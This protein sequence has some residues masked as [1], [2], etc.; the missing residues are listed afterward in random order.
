MY[1]CVCYLPPH[2]STYYAH[3]PIHPLDAISSD[4]HLLS[5]QSADFL[6]AGDFNARTACAP[7]GATAFDFIQLSPHIPELPPNLQHTPPPNIQPRINSDPEHPTPQGKHFLSVLSEHSLAIING[8]TPSDTPAALTCR[9]LN[10]N[11]GSTVDYF[12][13]SL[14]LFS[15][16]IDMEVLPRCPHSD[17]C[18]LILTIC[19][20][21]L[22]TSAPPPAA[23]TIPRFR[24]TEKNRDKNKEKNEQYRTALACDP[25]LSPPHL[26]SL[27][28]H[29]A[30]LLLQERIMH[31]ISTIY[32][33]LSPHPPPRH[34]NHHHHQP[35]FDEDCKSARRRYHAALIDPNSHLSH[36]RRL[37]YKSLCASKKTSHL[38]ARTARLL[39]DARHRP[40]AFWRHYRPPK[41][42]QKITSTATWHEY[43]SKLFACPPS[44]PAAPP[45]PP[46]PLTQQQA[47]ATAA[48]TLNTPI[49]ST[50]VHQ[51]LKRLRRNK[52]AGIDGMRAEFILDAATELTAPLTTTFN[53]L[54]HGSFPSPLNCQVVHS[55]FKGKG[56]PLD[57]N[58]Y[59]CLSVGPTLTKLYTMVLEARLSQWAENNGVRAPT[60]AGFR[61][62][63]RTTD[64][65]Y[66]LHTLIHQARARRRP[67]Y[68]CFVDFKKAFDSV[69]RP[70]LWLRLQEAGISGHMLTTLQSLYTHVT[71]R[72]HCPTGL[73]EPF[74]CDL[75]VKQGC[76]L[77]PLL[78]GLYIDRVA[79]L[80]QAADPSAP[81]LAGT[82]VACLLY[83]D[84]LTLLSTTPTG[85]Q[86]QL[87]TLHSFCLASELNVN[88]AKTEVV[89]FNPPR[90]AHSPNTWLFN[91]SP[92]TTSQQYRYL[93]I[94][95]HHRTGAHAAPTHLHAAGER[96]LHALYRRCTELQIH[97]PT[98]LCRL[99]DSLIT[100]VLSYGC[101]VWALAAPATQLS[102]PE[103]LHRHFLKRIA[104]MHHTTANQAVY[105]EFGRTPLAHHWHQL[106]ITFFRRVASLPDDRLVKRAMLEA[107]ALEQQGHATGLDRL[108]QHLTSLGIAATSIDELAAINPA[109]HKAAAQQRWAAD[110]QQQLAATSSTTSQ[111]AHYQTICPAFK[112]SPQPYLSDPSIPHLHCCTISRFRCGTHWLTEHTSRYL[113][114][115]ERT[116][117]HLTPCQTCGKHT[118]CEPNHMLL[119]DSCDAGYHCL[120]LD[121]PL[122]APPDGD[123]YCPPC[124]RSGQCH[125]TA[126]QDADRRLAHPCPHCNATTE[127]RHHFLFSCPFYQPLRDRFPTLFAATHTVQSWLEQ[128][129][130]AQIAHFLSS[131]Y[132]KHK[133]KS[134]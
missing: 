133:D 68:S 75:G 39:D 5:D 34:P 48:A 52:A 40:A 27:P 44:R 82:P 56:D 55:I 124:T 73:T 59:R 12:A 42:E 18:P 126:R 24:Y 1:L 78:F 23:P 74:P 41:T 88:L 57:P 113:R 129:S 9:N 69:P 21:Q 114:T 101:E 122:P 61:P 72:A 86:K 15:H 53:S 123:W 119:C 10:G 51:A 130:N 118:W 25:L 2:N 120:C 43:C 62:G 109:L 35:W 107:W 100:P 4:L 38:Q 63:Y 60:Q 30:A 37:E 85:L 108:Q 102:T 110:W 71:A 117:H 87:D 22:H 13:S 8:R 103:K 93:G 14:T 7:D 28:A 19:R 89:V 79:S 36:Q 96:A 115:A 105:G 80:I 26:S 99:F 16:I 91:G 104:G 33:P 132:K 32:P 29:E 121:P 127:D 134:P 112:F 131:C 106:A 81:T 125:P 76:P 70:L 92:V 84:D 11:G 95:F 49:D 58:N 116:R 47:W 83:A 67:L 65:I 31:H 94:I 111:T 90:R 45:L 54:F 17:H 66:T 128:S 50:E 98:L 97:T 3:L 46:L 20:T 64:H 77:S 6:L